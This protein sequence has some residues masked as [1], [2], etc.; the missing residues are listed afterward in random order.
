MTP[1]F[2]ALLALSAV[3]VTIN[4]GANTT[5]TLRGAKCSDPNPPEAPTCRVICKALR[6]DDGR[7]YVQ[8]YEGYTPLLRRYCIKATAPNVLSQTCTQVVAGSPLQECGNRIA[9]DCTTTS[10]AEICVIPEIC[11]C[12]GNNPTMYNGP[13]QMSLMCTGPN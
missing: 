8:T 9:Y 13:T 2:Y 6:G 1:R 4:S 3:L 5:Y 11:V 10:S 12:G 7:C